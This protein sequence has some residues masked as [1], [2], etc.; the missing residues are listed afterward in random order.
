MINTMKLIVDPTIFQTFPC[1]EIGVIVITGLNNRGKGE[2]ILAHLRTEEV[3]QKKL[4]TGVDIGSLPDIAAWRQ[5]YRKFGTDPHKYRSSVESL[6]RRVRSGEKPVPDINPLVNLYNYLSLKYHLPAGAEDL[7]KVVGDISLTFA[8][9]SEKGICLGGKTEEVCDKGE[10]IYKDREG[11][12]CRRW[13]WREADRTKIRPSTVNAVLVLEKVPEVK[14]ETFNQALS[15]AGTLLQKFL[16]AACT[17]VQLSRLHPASEFAGLGLHL[18]GVSSTPGVNSKQSIKIPGIVPIPGIRN[19][20]DLR[21]PV[22]GSSHLPGVEKSPFDAQ[23]TKTAIAKLLTEM[24]RGIGLK[25]VC[26]EV[27]IADNPAHGEY[28]SNLA[29]RLFSQ[30]SSIHGI[31]E[32]I[33]GIKE[34]R[35]P[36]IDD[37]KSPRDIALWV[38]LSIEKRASDI[39]HKIEDQKIHQKHHSPSVKSDQLDLLQAIDRVEVAGPGFLNF[40]FT[41]ASFISHMN[42]VLKQKESDRIIHSSQFI[43]HGKTK[44]RVYSERASSSR[45]V[46]VEYTDPNP[47]KELHIGHL[48]SNAV[49]E[50]LARLYEAMGCTVKRADYFGDVG[51]HVAKSI[52]G[53]QQ[54]VHQSHQT[55]LSYLSSIERRSL[56]ERVHILGQAYALG[57]TIYEEKSGKGDKAREGMKDINYMV[58]LAAQEY[59]Q[60]TL[61]WQPQVDY[62]KYVKV[63]DAL[64][65][66]ITLLFETGRKWSMDYFEG[67]FRR[68]GTTFD[69]YY[70][71]SI[72]GE[73]GA[74]IVKEHLADKVF[75]K[76]EG[77]I[78]FEGKA[79]GL[80]N[81]VFINSL[82]L[83]TYEAKELGLNWKKFQDFSPDLSLNVTGNEINEYFKVLFAVMRRVIPQVAAKT[84]HV[85]HGMVRI[86]S[87]K[88]SSRTG[89]VLTGE[90]LIEE[91]KK[92][93]YDYLTK[94]ESKYTEVDQKT[95]KDSRN[96]S[97]SDSGNRVRKDGGRYSQEEQETIA[98]RVAIAAIKYSFLR[99]ALPADL[100]FDFDKSLSLEGESGP[101]LLYTYARAKSVLRKALVTT[102]AGGSAPGGDFS[103]ANHEFFTDPS[104]LSDLSLNP[105]EHS[106]ARLITFYSDIVA[107]AAGELSPN[108]LCTYLYQLAQAFNVFYAKH[109]ILGG[110]E[111]PS[112]ISHQPSAKAESGKLIAVSSFRLALTA[113]TART[114][115]NGLYLLGIEIVERM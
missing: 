31:V 36:G 29:L 83:P 40:F 27:E 19:T 42:E 101:Y 32:S 66:E 105:E 95:A 115:A 7:D 25:D 99:V 47:F 91:V 109:T 68:L 62:R 88:M 67:I 94:S 20:K 70:P 2:E 86:P 73:Y 8:N 57:A 12:I 6:L 55:Y 74:K 37:W 65:R 43:A 38:Q 10:V 34:I 28:T 72:M 16:G 103:E 23:T 13:N 46:M 59:M 5:I 52:Y 58:Y 15:E 22:E 98:E 110:A 90:W 102:W 21:L 56:P 60:K 30:L 63:D 100:V 104:S 85:G 24:I 79:I 71:E 92:R 54:L 89:A 113:A 106:L 49:G 9:G 26:P 18:P 112:V 35:I 3:R 82:G 33:P 53:L 51:M 14:E 1:V 78:I 80:H 87:G 107:Q 97:N 61:G 48:Y 45:R 81:R 50:S 11:F 44:K 76:S 96:Q 4:L 39:G 77:A 84:K 108:K 114:L 64:Y 41:E 69:Y 93:V 111:K 17:V 75:T